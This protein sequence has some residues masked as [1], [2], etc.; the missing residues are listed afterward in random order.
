LGR[1]YGSFYEIQS[2]FWSKIG[3]CCVED[4]ALLGRI[5]ASFHEKQRTFGYTTGLFWA[6]DMR[7]AIS[8]H[9][10]CPKEPYLLRKRALFGDKR[11]RYPTEELHCPWGRNRGERIRALGFVSVLYFM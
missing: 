2:S 1:L 7:G 5:W 9:I 3:L 8:S 4:R 10:V 6:N 11:A